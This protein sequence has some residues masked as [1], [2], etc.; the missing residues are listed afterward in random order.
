M[1]ES[2]F[3]HPRWRE[4]PDYLFDTIRGLMNRDLESLH[5]HQTSSANRALATLRERLP[6][7]LLPL[8]KRLIQDAHAETNLRE[9]ARSALVALM[10][11]QRRLLMQLSVNWRCRGLIDDAEAIFELSLP[12]LRQIIEGTI[13][14][15]GIR[16]RLTDRRTQLRRWLETDAQAVFVKQTGQ[17]AHTFDEKHAI[18]PEGDWIEGMAVGTGRARGRA[19][20][21][22][23]PEEGVRLEPGEVLVAPSTDPSWTPLFLKAGGLIMETGG[24]LSHGAIVAREFGIPAVVHLPG[25]LE[26][27][28]TGDEVEVDGCLGRIR[29]VR[30]EFQQPARAPDW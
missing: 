25:I 2:Y 12:E 9:A 18:T 30:S 4:S 23:S 10:E 27:L 3:R 8:V 14:T 7:W 11:P 6:F 26:Q 1:Y 17:P 21:L 28:K 16:N 19:R 15:E 20:I 5:Q 22:R 13:G 24:Y 29:R